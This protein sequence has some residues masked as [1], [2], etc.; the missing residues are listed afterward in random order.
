MQ[1]LS[2]VKY[3]KVYLS[4]ASKISLFSSVCPQVFCT[5]GYPV[6]PSSVLEH[7]RLYRNKFL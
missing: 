4:L 7:A 5:F 2:A 3:A 1:K 6:I